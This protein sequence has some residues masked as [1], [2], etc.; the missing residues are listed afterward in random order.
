MLAELKFGP[1]RVAVRRPRA[2]RAYVGP[3]FSSASTLHPAPGPIYLNKR[4]Y[5]EGCPCS[6]GR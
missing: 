1:T 6:H 5:T 4:S 2:A 3:N